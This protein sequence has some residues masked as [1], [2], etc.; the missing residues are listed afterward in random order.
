MVP[1]CK[2]QAYSVSSRLAKGET[3]KLSLKKKKKK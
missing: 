3:V 1:T 2:R